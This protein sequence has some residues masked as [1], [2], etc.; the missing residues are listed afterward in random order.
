MKWVLIALLCLLSILM[1]GC[2]GVFGDS[3]GC[4]GASGCGGGGQTCGLPGE[5]C[6]DPANCPLE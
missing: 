4:G 5:S 2:T 3:I 1:V 6:D